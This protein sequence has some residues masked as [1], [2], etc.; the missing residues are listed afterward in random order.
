MG[1]YFRTGV[2]IGLRVGLSRCGT[3]SGSGGPLKKASKLVYRFYTSIIRLKYYL[4][5]LKLYIL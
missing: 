1:V 3:T 4:V 2:T 5:D